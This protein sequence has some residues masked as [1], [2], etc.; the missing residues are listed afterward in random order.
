MGDGCDRMI[1]EQETVKCARCSRSFIPLVDGDM[2]TCEMCIRVEIRNNIRCAECYCKAGD[3]NKFGLCEICSKHKL[4]EIILKPERNLWV[5][6][7]KY[8]HSVE[9]NRSRMGKFRKQ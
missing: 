1:E 3:I 5:D 6:D 8:Y 2:T 4:K 9:F 7:D